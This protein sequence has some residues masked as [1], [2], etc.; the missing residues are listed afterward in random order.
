MGKREASV[1]QVG[2]VYRVHGKLR[3]DATPVDAAEDYGDCKTYARSHA[4]YWG[5]LVRAGA[6]PAGEYEECPRGRVN[7]N[8][9]TGR[10]TLYADRCILRNKRLVGRILR[11]LQLPVEKTDTAIDSHY[12]CYRCLAQR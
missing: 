11:R 12:R 3:I 7:F 5:E 6:V 9:L 4:D 10:F 1:P 2:I 8:K